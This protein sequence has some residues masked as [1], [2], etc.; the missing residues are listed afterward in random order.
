MNN[1][2]VVGRERSG[3][4]YVSNLIA[5][6]FDVSAIQSEMHDGIIECNLLHAY[7][8]AFGQQPIKENK[9]AALH[10]LSNEY[11]F[12]YSSV[13]KDELFSIKFEDFFDLFNQFLEKN[14]KNQNQIG[15]VHKADA[16]S[17]NQYH[18]ANAKGLIIRRQIVNS[19]WSFF[20]LRD[21]VKKPKVFKYMLAAHC[22]RKIEEYYAKKRKWPI[23]NYE[24][25]INN[26]E[27]FLNQIAHYLNE[28]QKRFQEP[29]FNNSSFKGES[30]SKKNIPGYV[31]TF[32]KI[33]WG[34]A[35][36]IPNLWCVILL[37]VSKVLPKKARFV[38]KS[39]SGSV[40]N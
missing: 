27:N 30:S 29:A 32:D 3:T 39:F 33:A 18:R 16:R 5:S 34:I 6:N 8:K 10:T 17:L 1:I 14:A 15:W 26:K 20:K 21:K 7:P 24:F 2:L 38:D 19:T 12:K 11:F 9:L 22:Y 23:F 40:F 25:I 35:F 4:K 36:L 13:S 37:E 31:F 28:D